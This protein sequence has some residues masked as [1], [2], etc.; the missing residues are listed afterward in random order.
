[1]T[2]RKSSKGR[3]SAMGDAPVPEPA[4]KPPTDANPTRQRYQFGTGTVPSIPGPPK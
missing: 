4:Q 3:H 1:M 2:K